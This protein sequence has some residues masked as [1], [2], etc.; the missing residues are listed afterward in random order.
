MLCNRGVCQAN[1]FGA[2][3]GIGKQVNKKNKN[4]QTNKLNRVIEQRRHVKVSASEAGESHVQLQLRRRRRV[5]RVS[6]FVCILIARRASNFEF[7]TT[8]SCSTHLR[9][10]RIRFRFADSKSRALLFAR[11]GP[12]CAG[13]RH[14]HQWVPDAVADVSFLKMLLIA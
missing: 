4:K 14:R 6:R 3:Y 9:F 7:P 8:T 1:S 10:L 12:L 5:V 2:R 11:A 13:R